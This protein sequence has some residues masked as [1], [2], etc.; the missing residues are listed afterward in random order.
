MIQFTSTRLFTL[1]LLMLNVGIVSF[2]QILIKLGTNKVH[3]IFSNNSI[4]VSIFKVIFHPGIFWGTFLYVISL[5]LWIYILTKTK[6]SIA[7]P[8]MSVSYI[9]V[10]FLSIHFLK[11]SVNTL[12]WIG[13]IFILIGVST[14]FIFKT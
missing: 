11:E 10:M 12:Q 8:L 5:A 6:V 7:Y 3:H 14:I 9:A 13:A 4:I 2:A 1:G